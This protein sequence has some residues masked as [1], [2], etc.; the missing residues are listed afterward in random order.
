MSEIDL[1][2]VGGALNN[3]ILREH[4]GRK[5]IYI[6]TFKKDIK[7]DNI[8]F[9]KDSANEDN[10][11]YKNY[12]YSELTAQYWVW[13]NFKSNKKYIGFEH[14]R[15]HFTLNKKGPIASIDQLENIIKN[16]DFIVLKREGFIFPLKF[17]NDRSFVLFRQA[18][19]NKYPEYLYEFDKIQK[20]HSTIYRNMFITSK[21]IFDKYMKFVFDILFETER[22][23]DQNPKYKYKMRLLGYFGEFLIETF[24]NYN[25]FKYSQLHFLLEKQ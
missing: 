16:Y 22:L 13:K 20:G 4:P 19:K 23:F 18:I 15:R 21:S 5:I 24:M 14:Y 3:V 9:F 11:S 1:F 7:V 8:N 10:I 12:L 2:V 25:N 6:N 17:F